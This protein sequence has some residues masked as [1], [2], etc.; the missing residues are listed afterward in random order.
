MREH[1][2]AVDGGEWLEWEKMLSRVSGAV[3]GSFAAQR[4]DILRS[5]LRMG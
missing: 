2:L 4:L 5:Q 1:C 3:L